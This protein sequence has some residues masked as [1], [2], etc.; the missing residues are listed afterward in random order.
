[1]T[2][3]NCTWPSGKSSGATAGM[4]ALKPAGDAAFDRGELEKRG[5]HGGSSS[6][7]AQAKGLDSGSAQKYAAL[8]LVLGVVLIGGGGYL[9]KDQIRGFVDYF[10]EVVDT[11]GPLGCGPG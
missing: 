6:N 1:M 8:G 3:H 2:R 9:F 11:L 10:I 4:R 7:G 5:D